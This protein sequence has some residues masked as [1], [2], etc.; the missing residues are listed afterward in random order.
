[1]LIKNESPKQKFQTLS[2]F[3]TKILQRVRFQNKLFTTLQILN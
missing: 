3:K 2:D 1:M